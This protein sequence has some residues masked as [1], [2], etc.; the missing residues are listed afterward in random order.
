MKSFWKYIISKQGLFYKSLFILASSLLIL[1]IFPF[2][3]QFKYEFQKGRAWQYP[4]FYSPFDFSIL[5]TD[6]EINKDKEEVLK[7]LKPYLRSDISLRNQVF[8]NYSIE[9]YNFFGNENLKIQ[10][11]SLYNFG[12]QQLNEIYKF[13]VLPPNYIHKGNESI[14]L[15]QKQTE[16]SININQLF[17]PEAIFDFLNKKLMNSLYNEY[18]DLF[19]DLF[20]EII[21]PNITLDNE[22]FENKKHNHSKIFL[23]LKDLLHLEIL[24]LLKEN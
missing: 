12:F 11:D 20:F 3:G 7:S 21:A 6:D 13:G 8:K 2:G 24:L 14:F 22:F 19:N 23:N 9:F 17:R 5:K 1:Y 4:D 18:E 16:I 15:I 10:K